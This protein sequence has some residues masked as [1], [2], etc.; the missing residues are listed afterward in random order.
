M[1]SRFDRK[2]RCIY[3]LNRYAFGSRSQVRRFEIGRINRLL[4]IGPNPLPDFLIAIVAVKIEVPFWMVLFL[5]THD[6]PIGFD[7]SVFSNGRF[8]VASLLSDT[9]VLPDG[10]ASVHGRILSALGTYPG[11]L[12]EY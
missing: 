1:R 4:G 9:D 12:G 8:A 7:F 5:A 2:N 10:H 11:V 3:W 6:Y